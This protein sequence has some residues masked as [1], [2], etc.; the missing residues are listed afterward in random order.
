MC[1]RDRLKSGRYPPYLQRRVGGLHGHLNN[2]QAV[3]LLEAIGHRGLQVVIGHISEANNDLELIEQSFASFR[4]RVASIEFASQ[5][6][7][8]GWQTAPSGGVV[9]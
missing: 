2:Q 4:N 3:E 1:I 7:G 6:A 9:A 8:I 5:S